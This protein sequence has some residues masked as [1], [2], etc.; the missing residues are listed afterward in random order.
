MN[1]TFDPTVWCLPGGGAYGDGVMVGHLMRDREPLW[2][3]YRHPDG[4]LVCWSYAN[5]GDA[6][7]IVTNTTR[8]DGLHRFLPDVDDVKFP[9]RR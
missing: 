4:I 6:V 5:D 3:I 2:T 8:V 1:L 9:K 7:R